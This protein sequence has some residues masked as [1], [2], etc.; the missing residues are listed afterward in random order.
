MI[1][2]KDM[3]DSGGLSDPFQATE[4]G[5]DDISIFCVDCEQEFVWT[6]GEQEFFRDKGLKHSPKRCHDCKK[7]KSEKIKAD[8]ERSQ[9]IEVSVICDQCAVST[10]VP[11]YPSHGRPV[12]C[13]SC[14]LSKSKS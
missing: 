5:F 3:K 14:F 13:R 7:A 12:L 10:T 6:S 9:R 2:D 4:S 8:S 1:A 11:F